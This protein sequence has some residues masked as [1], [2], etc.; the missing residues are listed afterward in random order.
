MED[1]RL[2]TA[3]FELG[4]KI[5]KLC[6]NNN[7]LADVQAAFGSLGEAL[8]SGHGLRTSLVCL[9]A[10]LNEYCDANGLPERF[11]EKAVGRLLPPQRNDELTEIVM[12]L[13]FDALR[14]PAQAAESAQDDETPADDPQPGDGEKN[15]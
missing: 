1:I 5:Y 15:A 3:E 12:P 14:D 7:V 9:A 4:G 2:K 11:T 8:S 6:C 10:M 13:V